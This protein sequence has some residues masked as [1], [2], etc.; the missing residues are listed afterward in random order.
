MRMNEVKKSK[1]VN[2]K[3]MLASQFK[4]KK[5]KD[6]IDRAIQAFLTGATEGN[7]GKYWIHGDMLLY[8]LAVTDKISILRHQYGVSDKNETEQT[9]ATIEH[10]LNRVK[11]NEIDLVSHGVVQLTEYLAKLKTN[12]RIDTFDRIRSVKFRVVKANLIAKRIDALTYV[13]NSSVLPLIGRRVDFGNESL[14][15]EQ[16]EVQ[17]RLSLLIPMIPY[18][19]FHEAGLDLNKYKLLDR[20]TEE[21]VTRLIDKYDSKTKKNVKVPETVHF[22]GTSLFDVDGHT[23]LFD[24]DRREI[25][26]GVFNPFLAEIPTKVKTITE[27]YE[28]LKPKEVKDAEDAEAKGLK[29]LRQGEWFFIPVK[30]SYEPDVNPRF[31]TNEPENPAWNRKHTTGVLRAGENRP[32]EVTLFNSQHNLFSGTVTHSGREHAPLELKGWYS[33]I[34]NTATKSFTIT[35]DVD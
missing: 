6:E 27:A 22:T 16:T 35:G 3:I 33:A 18:T 20:G 15:R 1:G 31:D 11:L 19:V 7:W 21:Q 9:I 10:L 23:Y 30:G 29:V 34:P 12:E 2:T 4:F 32:N 14:N 13:G 25:K 28:A 8:K 26:E 24:I 17:R 5:P